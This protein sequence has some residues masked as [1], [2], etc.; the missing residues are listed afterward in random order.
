TKDAWSTDT[1]EINDPFAHDADSDDGTC[2]VRR[3]SQDEDEHGLLHST[4]TE[5]GRHPGRPLSWGSE[6][7]PSGIGAPQELE[8]DEHAGN[9]AHR[10]RSSAPYPEYESMPSTYSLQEYAATQDTGYEGHRK[11]NYSFSGGD[12]R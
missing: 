12:G 2:T 8:D 1:H 4:N 6:R 5:Y 10:R 9:E 11:G 3:P 7:R